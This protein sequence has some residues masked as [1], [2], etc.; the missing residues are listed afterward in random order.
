MNDDHR[1]IEKGIIKTLCWFDCFDYP[2]TAEELWRYGL[3][4]VPCSLDSV[5]EALDG[6]SIGN[7]CQLTEIFYHL[8]TRQKIVVERK[9]RYNHADQKFKK[10]LFFV[11]LFS[12]LPSVEFVAMANLIGSHNLRA[13]GDIDLFMIVRPGRLWTVRFL[14]A[15]LAKLLGVRPTAENSQDTICLSFYATSDNLA[16][17]PVAELSQFYFYYWL[18][19]LT[20]LYDRGGIH[21]RLLAANPW[22]F[23]RLPNFFAPKPHHARVVMSRR[24][25]VAEAL[26]ACCGFFEKSLKSWQLAIMPQSLREAANKDSRVVMNDRM[27][28]L[29]ANDRRAEFQLRYHERLS[30]YVAE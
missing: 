2:L 27:L 7:K 18:A 29:H 24:C 8:P 9:R 1:T 6:L 12:Y 23:G 13:G 21:E 30:K 14:T 11:R 25:L 22:L 3:F 16:L 5:K 10:A 17:E 28:K 4:S 26:E 20:P 19:F 15:A